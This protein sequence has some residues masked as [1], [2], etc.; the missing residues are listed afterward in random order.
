MAPLRKRGSAIK[1]EI[2]PGVEL[3]PISPGLRRLSQ[4][5]ELKGIV[6]LARIYPERNRH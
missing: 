3:D 1:Q 4:D 6:Y 2:K 5:R